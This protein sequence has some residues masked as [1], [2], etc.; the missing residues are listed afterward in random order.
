MIPTQVPVSVPVLLPMISDIQN[1][2]LLAT[3]THNALEIQSPKTKL[4]YEPDLIF[5]V[6]N[7]FPVSLDLFRYLPSGACL[8]FPPCSL[9]IS[10]YYR[11]S[12]TVP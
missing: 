10:P 8:L 3:E 1:M 4:L 5:C 11:M 6:A 2:I 7:T 12:H 9:S